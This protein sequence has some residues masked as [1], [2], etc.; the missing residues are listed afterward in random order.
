MQTIV[1]VKNP[2]VNRRAQY[3]E[4]HL[5]EVDQVP[6]HGDKEEKPLGLQQREGKRNHRGAPSSTRPVLGR[7]SSSRA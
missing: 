5:Q 1:R 2:G 7:D 4:A 3:C 6:N